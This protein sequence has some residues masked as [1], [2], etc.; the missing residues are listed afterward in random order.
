VEAVPEPLVDRRIVPGSLSSDPE[1]AFRE[2]LRMKA[3]F[4]AECPAIPSWVWRHATAKRFHALALSRGV[5]GRRLAAL[6][7]LG[8]AVILDPGRTLPQL[9]HLLLPSRSSSAWLERQERRRLAKLELLDRK[10]AA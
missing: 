2:W 6:P 3:I 9:L 7:P 8:I 5:A 10:S 4:Q 1:S